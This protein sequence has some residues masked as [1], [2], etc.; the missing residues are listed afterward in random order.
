MKRYLM[1]SGIANDFI[2]HR[3]LVDARAREARRQGAKI[4]ICVSVLGE[5]Y[6]GAE[7]SHTRE[8][9]L[10]RVKAGVRR[11]ICWPFSIAAAEEY[12]RI[13]ALLR[14]IGRPIGPIDMQ[15]AAIARTLANCVV[16]SKDSDLVAVPGLRVEN[17]AAP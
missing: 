17:W 4:G 15:I 12:G 6:A 16:V 3:P 2:N 14:Q 1:D 13:Y 5:L 11:L 8:V 7:W 10:Q 9:N